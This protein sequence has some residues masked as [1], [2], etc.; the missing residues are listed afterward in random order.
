MK[1]LTQCKVCGYEYNSYYP[2]GLDGMTPTYDICICCGIEFGY[3][4]C[5]EKSVL[6]ARKKWENSGFPWSSHTQPPL[7][8][9][10]L[11]QLQS[12]VL[13]S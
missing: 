3:E 11:K 13:S 6:I 2:W 9:N 12:V 4:D 1:N 7:N 5:S 10:P 8:W